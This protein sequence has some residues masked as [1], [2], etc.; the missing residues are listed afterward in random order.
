MADPGSISDG[1]DDNEF[2][3]ALV[4]AAFT[5]A[6]D[7]GWP[8]VTVTAAAR[9]AGL[10]LDRARTRFI[11]R[12]SILGRFGRIAD[13]A[14]LAQAAAEGSSRDRLFDAVMRRIDVLQAHRGGV[15]A[16]RTYLP[17]RP[18]LAAALWCATLGSMA[19]LLEASGIPTQGWRGA[20]RVKGLGVIWLRTLRAW[21]KD[22]S[23]DLGTTMAALEA[24]LN[25]AVRAE[26][27]LGGGA[28]TTAAPEAPSAEPPAGPPE[29]PPPTPAPLDPE[30][31]PTPAI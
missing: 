3:R 29:P 20:L 13:Q 4:S 2:D 31:P 21:E 18:M 8:A 19:W 22:E 23:E 26:G 7:L 9:A 28:A 15:L 27:W 10:P 24:G 12:A 11:G 30:T 14:A 17:P 5:L 25:Q 16:L 1:M 6:A